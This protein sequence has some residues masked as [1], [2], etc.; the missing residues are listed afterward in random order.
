ME[1]RLEQLQA[2]F[3]EASRRTAELKVELDYEQG[4]VE[5]GSIP[6]FD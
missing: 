2:E 3:S 1:D 6:H 4:V 5:R